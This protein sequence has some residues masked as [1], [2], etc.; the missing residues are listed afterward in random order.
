M[1]LAGEQVAQIL[2]QAGFRGEDL[3][4]MVGIGKRESSY[5]PG[6]YNGNEHTGDHSYGLFQINTLGSQGPLI[7]SILKSLG[8]S[9][10][11]QDLFD[12]MVN[13]QVAFAMYQNSGNK[14]TPWGGYKGLSNT[15]GTDLNAARTVVNNASNQGLLGANWQ[16]GTVSNTPNPTTPTGSFHLPPDAQVYNI[17]GTW[18]I[19]ATFDV[20]GVKV[21]Y[22]IPPNGAV[23]YSD[24]PPQPISQAD[25]DNQH[26]VDGGDAT[27]L[28]AIGP[29]FGS[30][31]GFWD[32]ITAQVMGFNNPAK[33]D[34][35]VKRVLAEFAAR[36]DMTPAE[37][38]NR[39]QATGWYQ[40]HTQGQLEWNGLPDAEKTK[41]M[42][43]IGSQMAETWGQF[44]GQS[45]DSTDPRIQNWVEKVASGQMGMGAWTEQ[46][47]KK[48]AKDIPNSPFNR[49]IAD[50]L[51]AEKTPAIDIENTAM[52]IRNT[53][54]DWGVSWSEGTIQDWA[55][56]IVNKD[57]SDDDLMETLKNQ[58]QVAYAWK[59][60]DM[61]TKDAAAPWLETMT[62]VMETPA[63]LVDPQVQ[64]A[65]TAG[66]PVWE[67]EQDL[68]KS[69]AWLNTKNAREQLTTLAGSVGKMMGFA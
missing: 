46:V 17:T 56:N 22:T 30:Y 11:F 58:A 68:K 27:E 50:E 14:L 12:P 8:R 28:G 19:Y 9:G 43:D 20:G 51:K 60:R 57:S 1:A 18:G 62:R 29:T 4:D 16:G 35:D 23:D 39:L 47:V 54:D 5:N 61:S 32:S 37:L 40:N 26:F 64:K 44:T 13:A 3:I 67:F 63:N 45:I 66:Q 38:Q 15:F 34:P 42:G 25:W 55:R 31:K 6:A 59:P 41:R 36:P 33:D 24:K 49:Q 52:R 65:L 53:L 7:R 69:D 2:Y 10:D 48:A 21:S